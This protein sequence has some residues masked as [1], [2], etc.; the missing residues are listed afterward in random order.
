MLRDA[1]TQK[2]AHTHTPWHSPRTSTSSRYAASNTAPPARMPPPS[3]VLSAAFLAR[4]SPLALSALCLTSLQALR[5]TNAVL[6]SCRPTGAELTA[7][8]WQRGPR[9]ARTQ[10]QIS[11]LLGGCK[12]GAPQRACLRGYGVTCVEP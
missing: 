11:M 6:L 7:Q 12:R 10:S 2:H 9:A 4:C 1:N 5:R 8:V 3:H